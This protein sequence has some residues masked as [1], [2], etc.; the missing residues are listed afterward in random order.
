MFKSREEKSQNNIECTTKDVEA[1]WSSLNIK[2]L[3][4]MYNFFIDVNLYY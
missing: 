2:V 1:S 4:I 3:S